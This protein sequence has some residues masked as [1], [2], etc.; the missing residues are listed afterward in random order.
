MQALSSEIS[1]TFLCDHFSVSR[2]GYYAWL[3]RTASRRNITLSEYRGLVKN[4]FK[5]FKGRYGSPRIHI[6]LKSKGISISEN[7]IAKLMNEEGL[8]ARKKK[9]FKAVSLD[10]R[11]SNEAHERIFKIE[12]NKEFK[13]NEVWAGDITYIPVDNKFLYL[14]VVMDLKRRKIVGWSIDETLSSIG[15]IKALENACKREREVA[16]VFHSDQG[17]QYKSIGFRDTLK[18]YKIRGSMSRRGNCYDNA[19]VETFFKT[20]K[21]ELLWNQNFLSEKHLKF[22][23]FEYIESW[24]NRKRIHSSL[25]NKSPLEYELSALSA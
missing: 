23:I 13:R 6:Y 24:Y 4:T 10:E 19:F 7:T 25:D 21:S 22:E 14:S 16:S 20:I 15:V 17:A 18:K 8:A 11:V 1:L 5:K 2:S 9:S 12:E 3:R